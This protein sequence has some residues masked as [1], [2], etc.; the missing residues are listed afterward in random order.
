M[1]LTDIKKCKRTDRHYSE[2]P[3]FREWRYLSWVE[4]KKALE[5][6]KRSI[7]GGWVANS[8]YEAYDLGNGVYSLS[9]HYNTLKPE[10]THSYETF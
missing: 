3:S 4:M 10:R 5:M 2:A 8:R 6:I 7:E 9:W 1:K